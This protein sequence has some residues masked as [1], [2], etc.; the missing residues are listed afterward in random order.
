MTMTQL[1][2][3]C[4]LAQSRF[5]ILDALEPGTASLNVAVRWKLL[6]QLPPQAVQRAFERIVARHESLRTVIVDVDG[7]PMQVVASAMPFTVGVV[8]LKAHPEATRWE[9]AERLGAIEATKPF[10]L[11]T[12]PLIRVTLL[13]LE[14]EV[15]LLLVTVHHAVS[16]GWSIGVLAREFMDALGAIAEGRPILPDALPLQYA[17]YAEWQRAWLASDG[18]AVASAY[19]ME[20]LVGAP[21]VEVAPDR[22]RG[23]E[24][25]KSVITSILLPQSV[26]DTMVEQATRHGCTMFA[27]ALAALGRMLGARTNAPEITIG[28]QVAGRTE[29]E[30]EGMVGSFINT[31]V[32]RLDLSAPGDVDASIDRAATVVNGAL[33]HHAMPFEMLIRQL[34]PP[35]DRSRTPLFAVNFIYQRSFVAPAPQGGVVLVDMPSHSAGALYDLNFFMV[36]R[37]A[38]WRISCEYDSALYE[39]ASIDTML[40]SWQDALTGA[41]LTAQPTED[42]DVVARLG[43]IWAKILGVATVQPTDGFFEIGGHSLLAAR[44]LAQ[45]EAVF[46]RRISIATLFEDHTLAGFASHLAG[47]HPTPLVVTEA[48]DHRRNPLGRLQRL[49]GR[50]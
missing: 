25:G 42:V 37:P 13:L 5:W 26:R 23:S 19:W 21:Y 4:S 11:D 24:R 3:P 29:I 2:A 40:R 27:V 38:G 50:D 47:S 31:L 12:L 18:P 1:T 36:E 35:R 6:G 33:E 28:T 30:L 49:F 22:P 16:D 32:L 14:P 41:A 44:M 17:D 7:E 8:D 10:Q 43:L 9:E 15:S 39:P 34:N 48:K 45:V 20:H 46:G